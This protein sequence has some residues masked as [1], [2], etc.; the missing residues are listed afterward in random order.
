MTGETTAPVRQQAWFWNTTVLLHNE[1]WVPQGL[2]TYHE[3][4]C[5]KDSRM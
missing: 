2:H 3:P 1:R 5:Y 4:V